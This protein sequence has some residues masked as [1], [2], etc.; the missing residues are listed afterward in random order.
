MDRGGETIELRSLETRFPCVAVSV[1]PIK[2]TSSSSSPSIFSNSPFCPPPVPKLARSLP[3]QEIALMQMPQ[4]PAK[5]VDG[6]GRQL[7]GSSCLAFI[8]QQWHH[9]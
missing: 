3:Q 8:W 7:E 1:S 6:T 9:S 2:E 5:H 4:P